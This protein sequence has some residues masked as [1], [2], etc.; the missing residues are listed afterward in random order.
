VDLKTTEDAL[1]S[2][3]PCSFRGELFKSPNRKE[4][5]RAQ[6][7]TSGA[8]AQGMAPSAMH[9]LVVDDELQIREALADTLSKNGYRIS[10]AANGLEALGLLKERKFHLLMTDISM[11]NM[12][13]IEL[14]DIASKIH[15]DMP[16]VLITGF[17]DV[18]MAKDCLQ[19]GA[20]DFIA[21]PVNIRE[22]PIIVERNLER[23]RLEAQRLME[24]GAQ[25]LLEAIRALAAAIDAK[26][27]YTA[28]HSHRVT[29]LAL[30]LGDALDLSSDERYTLQ[31]A[32]EM[33]DVGK[34]GMPEGVLNKPSN[35]TEDEWSHMRTH[36][37][38]GAEIVAHIEDL[39]GVASIIR[40]HHERI[41][42][43]GY[44]D[45]LKGEAI[46]KLARIIAVV[47][48]YDIMATGRT[49]C[50]KRSEE[51]VVAELSRER[52]RQFEVAFVNWCNFQ[53]P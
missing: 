3:I 28:G 8:A 46:P 19:R 21:K 5:A 39:E 52:D 15:P 16:I 9:I 1:P 17:G 4:P 47:D 10:T 29:E 13:G 34:I 38:K 33:H 26:D 18:E 7:K 48:A 41:D 44:P 12:S 14:L 20:S 25:I 53:S 35:L 24:K 11:P 42:G 49:Y 30:L 6:V 50:P 31:L 40:H 43:L 37:T 27:P 32:A 51:E 2:R 45:G 36:T 23:R 22:L